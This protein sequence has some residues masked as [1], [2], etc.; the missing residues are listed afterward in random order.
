[1]L[2]NLPIEVQYKVFKS[3]SEK[4]RSHLAQTSRGLNSLFQPEITNSRLADNLI[5]YVVKGEQAKAKKLLQLNPYLLLQKKEVTDYSG[6]TFTNLTAFQY[7]LWA[8][9]RHMWQMMLGC[10]PKEGNAL[11]N[12]LLNQYDELINEKITYKLN[13]TEHTESHYD[14]SPLIIALQVYV[15]VV[16]W[17]PH[18][19]ASNC[20]QVGDAQRYA[21]VHVA[22]EFCRPDRSFDP[23]PR[24]DDS[25]LP[26]VSTFYNYN[27]SRKTTWFP[28]DSNNKLGDNLGVSR[29]AGAQHEWIGLRDCGAEG[30]WTLSAADLSLAAMITLDGVR[31]EEL[32]QLKQQLLHPERQQLIDSEWEEELIQSPKGSSCTIL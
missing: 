4:E 18:L 32:L 22:N 8:L 20:N 26:R 17:D 16:V 25:N 9:D 19:I 11:R 1:M 15:Q 10:I 12:K 24:F 28:P 29:V 30:G 3:R 5:Q 21:P 31:T 13:G 27:N 2:E 23:T 14:F 6:R 7:A